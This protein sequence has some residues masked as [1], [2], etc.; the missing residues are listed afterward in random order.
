MKI[1]GFGDSFILGNELA[2]RQPLDGRHAW[3]GLIARRL[4]ADYFTPAVAGVGNEHIAQQIFSYFAQHDGQDTLAIINWTWYMRWD[5]RVERCETWVGL[6][7]T[8]VPEKLHS[9]VDDDTAQQMIQ[10]YKTYLENNEIW[11]KQRNLMSIYAAQTFLASRGIRTIQTYMD[12]ELWDKSESRLQHYKDYKDSAWPDI[13][14]V[15]DIQTL[16]QWIQQEVSKHYFSHQSL[17]S[18][19]LL[20]D[21]T[22][23][24]LRSFDGQDFLS[25]SYDRGFAVTDL[26]HPLQDAHDA[27]AEYWLP[28]YAKALD[29]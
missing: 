6:G 15:E 16:P 13:H 8:C 9:L 7:P 26:L 14:S 28:H 24:E 22:V 12:K 11:N 5:Y 2:D 19:D 27:A 29:V 10:F 25:W 18:I 17:P 1:V 20:Q 3:P 23:N 4:G 21:L